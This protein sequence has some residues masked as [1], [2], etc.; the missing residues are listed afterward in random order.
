MMRK[1]SLVVED[2]RKR[3][4]KITFLESEG[5]TLDCKRLSLH[6]NNRGRN[7]IEKD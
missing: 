4:E 7:E 2:L 1:V 5:L 3:Q 6:C